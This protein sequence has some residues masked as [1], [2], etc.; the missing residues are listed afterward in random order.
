MR[1]LESL[2][3]LAQNHL[4]EITSRDSDIASVPH[5]S[6]WEAYLGDSENAFS[7]LETLL[8]RMY[9]L[10]LQQV[11]FTTAL[12]IFPSYR[13]H[14]VRQLITNFHQPKS[15]LLLMISAFIGDAWERLYQHA[16]DTGYRFLSYGD[17]CLLKR[18][19]HIAK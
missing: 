11:H 14:Y 7:L 16:L 6:Q 8:E 17:A 4:E 1:T 18:N 2:Y 12:F 5:I 3:Y 9:Q 15:T 19:D 13:F 10:Q